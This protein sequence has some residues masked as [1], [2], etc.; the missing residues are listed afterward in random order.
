MPITRVKT[1]QRRQHRCVWDRTKAEANLNSHGVSFMEA[2]TM[3]EDDFALTRE[4][5]DSEDEQ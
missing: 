1:M 3:L 2:V 5:A 4:D